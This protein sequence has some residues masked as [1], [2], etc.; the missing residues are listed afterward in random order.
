MREGKV[1]S[2]Q[3]ALELESQLGP[4]SPICQPTPLISDSPNLLK[5]Q[6]PTPLSILSP[7]RVSPGQGVTERAFSCHFALVRGWP[8]TG[9]SVLRLDSHRPVHGLPSPQKAPESSGGQEHPRATQPVELP[10]P[11]PLRSVGAGP[12]SDA[13]SLGRG[14]LDSGLFTAHPVPAFC[15]RISSYTVITAHYFISHR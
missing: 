6:P 2:G 7:R 13:D 11:P 5:T 14:N 9:S 3:T 4:W 1:C 10:P 12:R 8:Q 15:P